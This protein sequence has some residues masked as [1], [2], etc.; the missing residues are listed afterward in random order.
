M[1]VPKLFEFSLNLSPSEVIERIMTAFSKQTE[2]YLVSKPFLSSNHNNNELII[3]KQRWYRNDFHFS[4]YTKVEPTAGG[5]KLFY[6][7]GL[8]QKVKWFLWLW[9]GFLS[10]TCLRIAVH[11]TDDFKAG[12]VPVSE[13]FWLLFPIGMMIFMY[14]LTKFGKWLSSNEVEEIV[15]LLNHEF[16]N[17]EAKSKT[18]I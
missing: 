17:S 3:Q 12:K 14:G 1:K 7:V 5:S 15:E 9:Y 11:I 8:N 18:G 10:F 6:R 13:Y 2:D 16:A 4:V